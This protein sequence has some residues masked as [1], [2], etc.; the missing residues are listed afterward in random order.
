MLPAENNLAIREVDSE[1]DDLDE[2]DRAILSQS[3][4]DILKNESP[5]ATKHLVS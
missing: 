3:S 5:E 4:L 2:G 1:E